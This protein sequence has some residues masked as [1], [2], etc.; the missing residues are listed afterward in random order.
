[1]AHENL[2]IWEYR[3]YLLPHSLPYL[4]VSHLNLEDLIHYFETWNKGKES[5]IY[6]YELYMYLNINKYLKKGGVSL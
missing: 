3:A 2:E 4:S 5:S 1:M 6:L